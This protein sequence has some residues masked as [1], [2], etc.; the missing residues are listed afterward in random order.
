MSISDDYRA[1]LRQ[2]ARDMIKSRIVGLLNDRML[3]MEELPYGHLSQEEDDEVAEYVE[4][5]LRRLL[6]DLL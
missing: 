3:I 1:E 5:C 2:L 4:T 6:D